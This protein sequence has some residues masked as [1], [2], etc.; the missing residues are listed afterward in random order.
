MLETKPWFTQEAIKFLE[1]L[2]Q[3]N[4]NIKVLEFGSGNS[5][6]W[7][8]KKGVN[9]ISIEH[10]KTWYET[11]KKSLKDNNL[12]IDLRF[13]GGQ[14]YTVCSEFEDNYFDLIIV[15]GQN[16]VKC[17]EECYK[18]LKPGGVLLL[19]DAERERYLPV[20]ELL[21]EWKFFK[22]V[23]YNLDDK[24]YPEKQTNWWIKPLIS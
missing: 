16:R 18:K 11:V 14:Y 19:D 8:A 24:E 5:T 4:P 12:N 9:L 23:E 17:I 21:K 6:I 7:L 2:I 13:I 3:I 20:Y 15:D 22:T 10:D 1:N